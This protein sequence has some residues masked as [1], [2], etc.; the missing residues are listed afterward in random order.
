MV[1]PHTLV[2]ANPLA[3]AWLSEEGCAS[4]CFG[5]ADSPLLFPGCSV[6]VHCPENATAQLPGEVEAVSG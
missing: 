6:W 5:S 3:T 4:V 1:L 2:W